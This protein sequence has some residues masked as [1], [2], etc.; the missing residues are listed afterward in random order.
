MAEDNLSGGR[1]SID[2]H[3][4]YFLHS[5][6]NP[7]MVLVSKP[8]DGMG[9]GA[10]KRAMEVALTAKNKLGFVNGTFKKAAQDSFDLHQWERCNGMVI[11]WILNSL[12]S[13]ISG[14]VIYIQSVSEM[15]LELLERFGQLSGSQLFQI[16][17]ELSQ[18]SQ[19]SSN[20]TSYFTKIKRLW[21]EIQVLGD[22][23]RCSCTES[24]K[25][26]KFEENQKLM[27][28]LM[29]LN[30]SYTTVR[31][32]ILMKQPLPAVRQAYSLLI[33]EEKQR[34]IGSGL[35]SSCDGMSFN[36]TS[37]NSSGS[38]FNRNNSQT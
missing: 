32:T 28:F 21:D 37:N 2:P 33:Q 29:G 4:P 26:Q 12:S 38:Y 17:K 25:S 19:G 3:H 27:Q 20:I 36:A 23:P 9:F 31:G 14:S 1:G 7:D 8:F 18:I 24:Q 35:Q 15:W 34:E 11:S 16:Q 22:L 5:S 30:D 13:D 6:D 10:W